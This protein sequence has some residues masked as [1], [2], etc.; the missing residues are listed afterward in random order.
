MAIYLATRPDYLTTQSLICSEVLGVCSDVD[1]F[2][3]I[4]YAGILSSSIGL[5]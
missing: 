4:R 5:S 3:A 1:L 2:S